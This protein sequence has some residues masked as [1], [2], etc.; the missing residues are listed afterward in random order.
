M[1]EEKRP[2]GRPPVGRQ[3]AIIISYEHLE[4]MQ[5]IANKLGLDRA[6]IQR[7]L[8]DLGLDVFHFYE[9][10]GVVKLIEIAN[11]NKERF[12]VFTEMAPRPE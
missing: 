9:K 11:R 1:K 3:I 8:I 5:R 7:S 12:Q 6:H 4:E 2:Q 10:I